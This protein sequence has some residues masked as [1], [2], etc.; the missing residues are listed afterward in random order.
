[1]PEREQ[2]ALLAKDDEAA[3]ERFLRE[4]KKFILAAA[5]RAVGHY[6]TDSDD[7]WSIALM[8]FNE[9]IDTFEQGKGS[10]FETFA[11]LV[12]KRR[13]LNYLRSESKH[14]GEIST[15]PEVID[16][17]LDED[18]ERD[19]YYLEVRGKQTEAAI[20]ADE[21]SAAAAEI[22]AVQEILAP[23]GFSLMALT[24]CSPKTGKT[25]KACAA[26]VNALL[27]DK[28]L[29][30][31]MRESKSLP[32]KELVDLTKVRRQLLERHRRYIIAA[33]EILEIPF[34][35]LS[36]YMRFIKESVEESI[37]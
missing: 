16:G 22:A 13:V 35:L 12:I 6:V 27:R 36:E 5:Y 28:A 17:D 34:P 26:A 14:Q 19:A 3:R 20:A 1:M 7:E 32:M 30:Q 15:K 18:E 11:S 25:R 24:E 10:S 2:A 33:T 31:K 4:N 21:P 29:L 8:A 9:A 37:A 23:Y